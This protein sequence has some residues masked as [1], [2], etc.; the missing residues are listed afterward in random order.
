FTHWVSVF[1][2]KKPMVILNQVF[3]LGLH[4]KLHQMQ[5]GKTFAIS[6]TLSA[7][8][9]PLSYAVKLNLASL[10][11]YPGRSRSDTTSLCCP[12]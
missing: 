3:L 2:Q 11:P 10:F 7:S 8:L 9:R 6:I 12:S 1:E 4:H 5:M